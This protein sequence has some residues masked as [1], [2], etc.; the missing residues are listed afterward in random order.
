MADGVVVGGV[1]GEVEDGELAVG[2][3]DV[4]EGAVLVGGDERSAREEEGDYRE[5][6]HNSV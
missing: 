4:V 5:S 1:E 3:E 2:D 6:T